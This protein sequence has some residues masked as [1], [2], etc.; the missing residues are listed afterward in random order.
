MSVALTMKKQ[1]KWT[2]KND[3][4]TAVNVYWMKKKSLN[5]LDRKIEDAIYLKVYSYSR[6]PV[7]AYPTLN[8][9]KKRW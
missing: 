4:P 1:A 8:L 9:T 2:D 5:Q 6:K 7:R 3:L